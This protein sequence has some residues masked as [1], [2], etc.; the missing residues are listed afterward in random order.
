M[1]RRA[2]PYIFQ[3]D[4]IKTEEKCLKKGYPS[5]SAEEQ[6]DSTHGFLLD[7]YYITEVT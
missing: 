3:Y 7:S 5:A 1:T 2:I 6:S 4:K